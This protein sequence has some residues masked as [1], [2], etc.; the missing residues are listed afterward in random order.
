[1]FDFCCCLFVI[2]LYFKGILKVDT[3]SHLRKFDVGL[4]LFVKFIKIKI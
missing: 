3:K 1:M 2:Y 4:D